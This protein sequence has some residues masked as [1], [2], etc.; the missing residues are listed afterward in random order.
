MEGFQEA[1]AKD[2]EMTDMGI[3]FYFLGLYGS[4]KKV[5]DGEMQSN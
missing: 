2:S 3:M 1:M 4:P 5:Q